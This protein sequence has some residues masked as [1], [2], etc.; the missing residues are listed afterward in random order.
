[1]NFG[2]SSTWEGI[3]IPNYCDIRQ[4]EGFKNV[5][6]ANC[7]FSPKDIPFLDKADVEMKLKYFPALI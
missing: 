5:Y 3:N 2:A 7:I 6:L 1:L 4:E